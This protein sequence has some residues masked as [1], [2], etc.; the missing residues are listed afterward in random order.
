MDVPKEIIC[1]NID[2]TNIEFSQVISFINDDTNNK[3]NPIIFGG[4]IDKVLFSFDEFEKNITDM[5]PVDGVKFFTSNNRQTRTDTKT[6]EP[7]S[8]WHREFHSHNT[9]F[10]QNWNYDWLCLLYLDIE[11]CKKNCGTHI[12]YYNK[13]GQCRIIE[14]QIKPRQFILFQDSKFLHK[15]P[16][17]QEPID[18]S[19]HIV[20]NMH[21]MYIATSQ[22]H[23]QCDE[24]FK[25][26][27]KNIDPEIALPISSNL[28]KH[29]IVKIKFED[30]NKSLNEQLI[31]AVK[32]S[33]LELI[34]TLLKNGANLNTEDTYK[35]ALR[36]AKSLDKQNTDKTQIVELIS[37]TR[38]KPEILKSRL[39]SRS[40]SRSKEPNSK[41]GKR[42]KK[43][44]KQKLRKRHDR[45]TKKR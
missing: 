39:K 15:I 28:P 9:M 42:R 19:K 26:H 38:F 31:E 18:E 12:M 36:A 7:G 27:T 14:L 2:V 30:V 10:N 8:V 32:T 5:V 21:R 35:Q 34:K 43:S 25:F 33:D 29:K 3:D 6:V 20:R 17:N 1:Y 4:D 45:K 24:R 16:Y 41:G 23:Q 37:A 40:K 22:N 13:Y 11:N 44:I